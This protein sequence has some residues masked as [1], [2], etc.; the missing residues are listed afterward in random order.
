MMP[1]DCKEQQTAVAAV[2]SATE[3]IFRCLQK[4][5]GSSGDLKDD[6]L[7]TTN[8]SHDLHESKIFA[9]SQGRQ[10]H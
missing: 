9:I 3:M 8:R 10:L 4:A 6:T 2:D 7:E 1:A 5:A